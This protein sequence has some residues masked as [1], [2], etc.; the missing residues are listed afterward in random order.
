VSARGNLYLLRHA[1]SDWDDPALAD[2]ERPLNGRGRRSAIEVSATLVEESIAPDVVLVS[3]ARRTRQTASALSDALPDDAEICIEDG[4][5]AATAT[6]LLGRIR[7]LSDDVR[8]VLLIGHNPGIEEL[9]AALARPRY[10]LELASGM[11]TASLVGMSVATR[12]AELAP[13]TAELIGRW[14]HRGAKPR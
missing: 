13:S 11:R 9:A 2:H 1:K 5:Y 12:W 14:E 8:T 6:E 3:S 10:K 7:A 4:L